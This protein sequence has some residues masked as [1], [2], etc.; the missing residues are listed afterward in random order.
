MDYNYLNYLKNLKQTHPELSFDIIRNKMM[1]NLSSF[2]CEKDSLA[3]SGSFYAFVPAGR[4]KY[5]TVRISD[6]YPILKNMFKS[7][8]YIPSDGQ[9][10]NICL[11][12]FG[13]SSANKNLKFAPYEMNSKRTEV[14]ILRKDYSHLR[15]VYA[16]EP[17]VT[18]RIYHYIPNYMVESDVDLIIN[19]V[20]EWIADGGKIEYR[21][22]DGLKPEAIGAGD[23]VTQ[24]HFKL[25]GQNESVNNRNTKDLN[26]V[27]IIAGGQIGNSLMDIS[28]GTI[29]FVDEETNELLGEVEV[30]MSVTEASKEH[31]E[32]LQAIY[33]GAK[34]Q[35]KSRLTENQKRELYNSIMLD[36]ARVVKK[37]L[38]DFDLEIDDNNCPLSEVYSEIDYNDQSNF[39]DWEIDDN[40]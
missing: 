7:L 36:V 2:Y 9:F 15:K 29:A 18:Y 13:S 33:S 27:N 10:A 12:F 39:I 4:Q 14:R 22:P 21:H 37:R 28:L 16:S 32:M 31:L 23:I 26:E 8:K 17:K 25:I 11:M 30:T 1:T 40:D 19:S 24:V 35:K 5:S 38:N 6:H 3:N 34:K 20:N